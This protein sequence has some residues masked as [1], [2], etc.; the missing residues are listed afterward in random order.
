M[1][2]LTF[3]QHFVQIDPHSSSLLTSECGVPQGSILGP[4]L[5]NLCVVDITRMNV[6]KMQIIQHTEHAK[7]VS[8]MHVSTVLRKIS[9]QFGDGQVKQILFLT[10]QKQKLWSY[11][12]HK[13]Q[14]ITNL[15]KKK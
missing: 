10:V 7:Q 12:I 13:C 9:I 1:N 4:I 15:K 11:P 6:Y 14:N 3:R 8:N 5:L 2:Y